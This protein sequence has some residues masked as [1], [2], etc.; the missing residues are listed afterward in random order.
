M[1]IVGY[2]AWCLSWECRSA[3]GATYALGVYDVLDVLRKL[4]G[5]LDGFDVLDG[6]KVLNDLEWLTVSI[7]ATVAEFDRDDVLGS[8]QQ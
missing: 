7:C 6:H 1:R 5:L 3:W 4:D 8:T 2:K